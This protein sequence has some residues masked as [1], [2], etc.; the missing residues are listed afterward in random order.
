[1]LLRGFGGRYHSARFNDDDFFTFVPVLTV[2]AMVKAIRVVH[3]RGTSPGVGK[4]TGIFPVRADLLIFGDTHCVKRLEIQFHVFVIQHLVPQCGPDLSECKR[5][6]ESPS[7]GQ[8]RPSE[9][10]FLK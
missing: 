6:R 2:M 9:S 8:S 10:V 7:I 5:D 3:L 1:L 4:L